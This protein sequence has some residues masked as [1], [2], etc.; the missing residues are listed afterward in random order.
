MDIFFDET[1]VLIKNYYIEIYIIPTE[2]KKFN[3]KKKLKAQMVTKLK[4]SKCDKI[5][6][7][8]L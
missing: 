4:N 3:I 8:K 6:K 2:L 5:H 7:L 1:N